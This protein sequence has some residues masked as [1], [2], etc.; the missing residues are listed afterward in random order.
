MRERHWAKIS[1]LVGA[2]V[3]HSEETSLADMVEQGVHV[4]AS[5]LEEIEQYASK[6]YSLEKALNKMKEEWVGVK[7]EVV[8][9]RFVFDIKLAN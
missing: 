9:Y 8:L 7:F 2:E 3:I 6:E 5:Q 1:E 4:F